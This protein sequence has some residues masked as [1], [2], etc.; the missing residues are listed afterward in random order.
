MVQPE[1]FVHMDQ[2]WMWRWFVTN[3]CGHALAMSA[4]RFFT[5][6]EAV[7]N[8]HAARMAVSGL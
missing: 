4:D 3:G 5:R 7:Q 1:W 8:L 6:E 2:E